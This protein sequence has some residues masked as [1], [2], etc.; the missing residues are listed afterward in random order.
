MEYYDINGI[1]ALLAATVRRAICDARR[2]NVAA[3]RWLDDY[4]PQWRRYERR[5]RGNGAIVGQKQRKS[6]R[7]KM[8][9]TIAAD[10]KV[11]RC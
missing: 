5:Q 2:G 10:E 6:W 7:G 1:Y 4:Y 9:I 8:A 11:T 3:E